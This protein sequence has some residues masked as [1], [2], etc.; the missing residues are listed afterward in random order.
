M[1]AAALRDA[2]IATA[3]VPEPF[4]DSMRYGLDGDVCVIGH[5]SAPLNIVMAGAGDC[6]SDPVA[7]VDA[8]NRV[9]EV[10]RQTR[11]HLAATSPN[12]GRVEVTVTLPAR[13][14]GMAWR[15]GDYEIVCVPPERH[16]KA[17]A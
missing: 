9:A 5:S 16:L 2:A 12:P 6:T 17:V 1:N 13:V 11:A 14:A 8:W 10:R 4:L 7:E 3:A 15:D